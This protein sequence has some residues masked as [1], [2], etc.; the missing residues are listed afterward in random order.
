M[1]SS[2]LSTNAMLDPMLNILMLLC[3]P[4]PLLRCTE[5][6]SGAPAKTRVQNHLGQGYTIHADAL[7]TCGLDSLTDRR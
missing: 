3:F 2:C 7:E 1:M 5:E 4:L 6:N